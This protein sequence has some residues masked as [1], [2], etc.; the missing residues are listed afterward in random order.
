MKEEKPDLQKLREKWLK[1]THKIKGE[2]KIWMWE[3]DWSDMIDEY[4][5]MIENE[6]NKNI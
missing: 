3:D 5:E 1:K 6:R 4:E 2:P